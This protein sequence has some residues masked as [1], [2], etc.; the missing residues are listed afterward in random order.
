LIPFVLYRVLGGI[1]IGIASM[2]SP[3]YIAEIAP[4]HLRGRLVSLNQMAI[5]IGIVGVYFVNWAIARQGDDKCVA[6]QSE[7]TKPLKPRSWRRTLV[8]VAKLTH[9]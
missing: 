8:R 3:L 2:L 9:A 7:A 4:P 5:V 6:P 1:G